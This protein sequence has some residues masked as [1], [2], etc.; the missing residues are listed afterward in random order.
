[1][2][3]GNLYAASMIFDLAAGGDSGS[4][5]LV[6]ATY[7]D[8]WGTGATCTTATVGYTKSSFM[9]GAMDLED[10]DWS[11][12]ATFGSAFVLESCS[13]L[14]LFQPSTLVLVGNSEPSG[15]Y[16]SAQVRSM[17]GFAMSVDKSR[18]EKGNGIALTTSQVSKIPY[19]ISVVADANAVYV[20]SLTTTD[21]ALSGEFNEAVSSTFPNWIQYQK[22]GSCSLDMTVSKM[23]LSQSE[24]CLDSRISHQPRDR[25]NHPKSLYWRLAVEESTVSHHCRKYPWHRL[26]LWQR[27]RQ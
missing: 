4:V 2:R 5:Y 23:T 15:R 16:A 19:P 10:W 24:L 9:L 14:A 3:A 13:S 8:Q 18:F 7:D 26:W 20:V 1:M 6:G 21:D 11:L 27:Q 22:Y 17:T 25:W 12:G